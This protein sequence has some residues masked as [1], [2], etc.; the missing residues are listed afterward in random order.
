MIKIL[1]T[2]GAGFIPSC[3]ADELLATGKYYVVAVDN[4]LTGKK[5]HLSN[6]A[7]YKFIK[8]DVND[9]RDIS[10]VMLHYGFDYLFHYAAVVGVQRTLANQ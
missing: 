2:G 6:H 1:I 5:H 10:T 3:L 8:C 9:V 7:N 4:F